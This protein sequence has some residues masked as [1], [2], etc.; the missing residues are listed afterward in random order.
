MDFQNIPE[1]IYK[2]KYLKYK[3]KYL[4]LSQYGSGASEGA[5]QGNINEKK[6]ELTTEYNEEMKQLIEALPSQIIGISPEQSSKIIQSLA[7]IFGSSYFST[8][9][10]V[11]ESKGI[12]VNAIDT[13]PNDRTNLIAL[14]ET[15]LYDE[16]G[17]GKVQ[18]KIIKKAINEAFNAPVLSKQAV[19]AYVKHF[20]ENA[21]DDYKYKR[22]M[23]D[24]IKGLMMKNDL[25]SL[26]TLNTQ[27]E[28]DKVCDE[29]GIKK[30]FGV[31]TNNAPDNITL[32]AQREAEFKEI[33]TNIDAE[34][35]KNNTKVLEYETKFIEFQNLYNT[36]KEN[37]LNYLK[38]VFSKIGFENLSKVKADHDQD[39][40]VEAWNKNRDKIRGEFDKLSCTAASIKTK[41]GRCD[42]DSIIDY[43]KEQF[44]Q[45]HIDDN[46]ANFTKQIGQ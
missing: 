43:L 26:S 38:E 32:R 1:E 6:A 40:T 30:G 15:N 46:T 27:I 35:I 28:L 42:K 41:S 4:E 21:W 5:K 39:D 11:T 18:D 33:Y 37:R 17:R 7:D 29:I 44:V 22:G 24:S 12:I 10:N 9:P 19:N 2:E 23:P 45:T 25:T 34:L 36:A 13:I 20:H 14:Y 3:K 16:K 31:C 8:Y